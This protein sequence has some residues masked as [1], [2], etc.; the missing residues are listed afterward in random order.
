[1]RNAA[2]DTETFRSYKSGSPVHWLKA[3][4]D[5]IDLPPDLR[6]HIN[7]LFK[8]HMK[9]F[10]VHP[11]TA[12]VLAYRLGCRINWARAQWEL[13]RMKPSNPKYFTM[14]KVCSQWATNDLKFKPSKKIQG[15]EKPSRKRLP[16]SP[17]S[18]PEGDEDEE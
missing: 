10:G 9:Y 4:V 6:A 2:A 5:S 15:S 7:D 16:I 11:D 3:Q 12:Q 1:M 18:D 13:L 8:G 17:V 14:S